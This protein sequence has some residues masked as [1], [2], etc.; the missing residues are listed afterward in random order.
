MKN[1]QVFLLILDFFD[2]F[3]V[4]EKQNTYFKVTRGM[5]ESKVVFKDDKPSMEVVTKNEWDLSG[6]KA[7]TELKLTSKGEQSGK[8]NHKSDLG[9]SQGEFENE[10]TYN[11]N[12]KS[13]KNRFFISNTFKDYDLRH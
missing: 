13:I 9:V 2:K 5:F 3:Y 6:Y 4:H 7:N 10:F 12:D 8:V 1:T 11:T